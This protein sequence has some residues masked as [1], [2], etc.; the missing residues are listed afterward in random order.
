MVLGFVTE[1]KWAAVKADRESKTAI[2]SLPT[3]LKSG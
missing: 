2:G 3:Q 1:K